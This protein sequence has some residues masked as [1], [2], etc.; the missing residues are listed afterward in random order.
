MKF[1]DFIKNGHVKKSARD[2]QLANAL[3]GTAEED[4]T[5]LIYLLSKGK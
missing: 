5:F 4:L 3:V 2:F 1:E